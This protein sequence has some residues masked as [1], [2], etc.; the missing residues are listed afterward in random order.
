MLLSGVN[1][2][3]RNIQESADYQIFFILPF[4]Y[5]NEASTY[6]FNNAFLD[7]IVTCRGMS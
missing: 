4:L 6:H 7:D 5:A 2:I 3:S 1:V